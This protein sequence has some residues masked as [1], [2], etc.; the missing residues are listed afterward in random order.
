[1]PGQQIRRGR[2]GRR[3]SGDVDRA[4]NLIK[5]SSRGQLPENLL[6]PEWQVFRVTPTQLSQLRQRLK[7]H[8][9]L[10]QHFENHLRHDY[11]PDHST[12][13]LRLM[14]TA[15]HETL[16]DDLCYYIRTQLERV[17]Q[18]DRVSR[19]ASKIKSRGHADL[20][21]ASTST[22]TPKIKSPDAQLFY[23]PEILSTFLAEIGYNQKAASLQQLARD[24]RSGSDGKIK[25]ILTIKVDYH[26][27]KQ[28]QAIA[29]K[30]TSP[31]A[32]PG[33]P[34]DRK[35]VL[36]LYRGPQRVYKDRVFRDAQGN[37]VSDGGFQLLLSD[38][39]P[40]TVLEALDPKVQ[41]QA[42][43]CSIDIPAKM[44]CDSLAESEAFQAK[45]DAR[46]AAASKP[47]DQPSGQSRKRLFDWEADQ[48]D[49]DGD[50][51]DN[52]L[53]DASAGQ[54]SGSSF[55]PRSKRPRTGAVEVDQT[56]VLPRRRTRS[57]LRD[58]LRDES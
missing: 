41:Q 13:V 55:A 6:S 49:E 38:F 29:V 48:E 12:L 5:A 17:G 1:M 22:E 32:L 16:Q 44:L 57:Q 7:E 33:R 20:L 19:L 56:I 18:S 4:F 50:E 43:E 42:R 46:K 23:G 14:A 8:H 37:V 34:I 9:G 21:L 53:S 24:Y 28:R 45:L 35:A 47:T 3:N 15:I 40:D 27:P 11:D 2:R 52:L 25:T 39:L 36:C 10:L 31:N 51:D 54:S 58:E 26:S 30:A